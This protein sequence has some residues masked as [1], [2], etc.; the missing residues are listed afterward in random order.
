MQKE[1][2]AFA[3]LAWVKLVDENNSSEVFVSKTC[4]N[5]FYYKP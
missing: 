5:D 4:R 1:S 3:K 2:V